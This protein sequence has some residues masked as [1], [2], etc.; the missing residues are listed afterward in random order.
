MDFSAIILKI[1]IEYIMT[2]EGSDLFKNFDMGEY[3]LKNFSMFYGTKRRVHIEFP[4]DKVGI[5]IDRLGLGKDVKITGP[6]DVV[7]EFKKYLKELMN[8]YA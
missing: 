7:G 1:T 4:N 6:N 2:G 3:A 5:F 8:I